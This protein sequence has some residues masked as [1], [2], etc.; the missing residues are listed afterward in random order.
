M[1]ARVLGSAAAILSLS[2][3]PSPSRAGQP[4]AP[5]TART[6][7][8]Q[9]PAPERVPVFGAGVDVVVLDLVVRDRK[10]NV[11]RDLRPE[12]VE[13]YEDGVRQPTTEFRTLEP[14]ARAGAA[15][16]APSGP[17]PAARPS[18][19]AAPTRR[20]HR[21]RLVTLLF[22]QLSVEG[23]Q[24]AYRAAQDFVDAQVD[25]EAYVA[26]FR[27]DGRLKLAQNFTRDA[28]AVK[29]AVEAATVGG[30]SAFSST[31]SAMGAPLGS[32]RN[33]G[34]PLEGGYDPRELRPEHFPGDPLTGT[35]MDGDG[36]VSAE[37]GIANATLDILRTAED[38]ER[39]Q[40]GTWSIYGLLS[41]VHGQRT[42]PGRKTLVFFS[43][44]LQVPPYLDDP[45]R[46]LVSEANRANVSIY[47]VDVRGLGVSGNV[48]G[49]RE[50]LDQAVAVSMSQRLAGTSSRPVTREQAREFETIETGLRMNAQG[51]LDDLS[52]GTGGFLI[53]ESNDLKRG[54]QRLGEDISQYYEVAYSPSGRRYDGRF[55][56]LE[57]KVR[58]PGASVQSRAGY[59][60]IPH[61]VG[62][63][64]FG[65]EGPLLVAL[66]STKLPHRFEH[67]VGIFRFET[68]GVGVLHALAVDAPLA[69]V[70]F[71]E[72][73]RAGR[74]TGRVSI[75]ALVKDGDGNIVEKLGQDFLLEG[76]LAD[77]A[78]LR[79]RRVTFL[80]HF[81]LRPGSY[82]VETAVRDGIADRIGCR[83]VPLAVALPAAGVGLSSV[84]ALAGAAPAAGGSEERDDPFRVGEVRMTPE[85]GSSLRA[86]PGRDKLALYYVVY[87]QPGA[88]ETPRMVLEIGRDGKVLKR[89]AV[90][91]PEADSSGRIQH[92]ASI[93]LASLAPGEYTLRLSVTQ[94]GSTAT[95]QT[96]VEVATPED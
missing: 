33:S 22:D 68:D 35:P 16:P 18:G 81:S 90:P 6:I 3:L 96:R 5:G 71:A 64:V 17:T 86:G 40:R 73:G 92:V 24:L 25:P 2:L 85:L 54:F 32:S 58:R 76:A 38:A 80:R 8:A 69:R 75:L 87:P 59:F 56:R 42:L 62:E 60:A 93:P 83:R 44:G 4:P 37:R 48:A 66:A 43:E 46:S 79:Q 47:G 52:T 89:G 10:G 20:P 19:A 29:R 65:Y 23:R 95:E 45:F 78:S 28:S 30:A 55:R 12:E 82:S 21:V 88:G 49:A 34:D 15:A 1:G 11:V 27:I 51:T 63:P 41:A 67:Q 53:A 26:V 84:V 77:L 39:T 9:N 50:L 13:V 72:D 94:D 61:K 7:W 57:V 74:F 14:V 36:P 91:L 70:R 31:V